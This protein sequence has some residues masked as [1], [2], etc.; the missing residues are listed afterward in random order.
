MRAIPLALLLA[1]L[2][3]ACGPR[4]TYRYGGV[5]YRSQDQAL[6]AAQKSHASMVDQ[7]APAKNRVGGTLDV[8]VPDR[9]AVMERGIRRTGE[10]RQEIL[11][12]VAESSMLNFQSVYDALVKRNAFDR[13][14]MHYTN[15]QHIKPKTGERAVYLYMPN[16]DGTGWF[17][18]SDVVPSERIHFDMTKPDRAQR[19]QYWL[20]S[21]EALAKIR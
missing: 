6:A 18:T 17:Y 10:P 15:G 11:D 8:Y 19:V 13:V 14:V 21:V 12:Y 20:E 4:L 5:A 3:A 7:I 9:S 2:L 16:V 1:V